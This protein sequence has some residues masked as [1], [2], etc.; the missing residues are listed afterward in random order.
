MVELIGQ[1]GRSENFSVLF[2][3]SVNTHEQYQKDLISMLEAFPELV[4]QSLYSRQPGRIAH[5][6]A[7]LA[8]LLERYLASVNFYDDHLSVLKARLGLILQ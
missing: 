2:T 8:G 5:Y 1:W 6:T 4:R 7:D 3:A